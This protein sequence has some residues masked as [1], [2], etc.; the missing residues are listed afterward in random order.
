MRDRRKL[1][2][3]NAV[4]LCLVFCL[5]G[6]GANDVKKAQEFMDAGMYVQA[7]ELLSKRIGEKPSDPDAHFLMGICNIHTNNNR[8][9]KDRF[10]SAVRL[11]PDYGFKIGDEYRKAGIE[12]LTNADIS[13]ALNL[14]LQ[15]VNYQPG[16]K[17]EIGTELIA[18]GKS[19][20]EKGQHK[21]AAARFT[22][23]NGIKPELGT[24]I[25][26]YYYQ[27]G[28]NHDVPLDLQTLCFDNAV[29]YDKKTEYVQAH[30][31]HHYELS[32]A[33]KTTEAAIKELKIAN[34]SGG[35]FKSELK[36][37]Q[38]QLENEKLMELVNKYEAQWGPVKKVTLD[39]EEWFEV[40]Q[41]Q[42]RGRIHYLSSHDFLMKSEKSNE[43]WKAEILDARGPQFGYSDM[44][45]ND[46]PVY[47]KRDKKTTTVYFW[48]E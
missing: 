31:D 20:F 1:L 22:A 8:A 33:A 2:Y 35:K 9:A 37:K 28:K 27:T 44:T 47:F 21:M 38:E 12:A 48:F 23:A 39:K 18:E 41:V 32:K 42:K 43:S 19:L 15:A 5:L 10:A 24:T 46:T 16:L 25:A 29:K 11:K 14:Y 4:V 7:M 45:G 3:L 34:K 6:C 26:E 40:G 17:D 30:A 36:T 13:R